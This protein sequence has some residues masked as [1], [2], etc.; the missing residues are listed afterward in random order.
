MGHDRNY[1]IQTGPRSG[2]KP[3]HQTRHEAQ[4]AVAAVQWAERWAR[5]AGWAPCE[6]WVSKEVGSEVLATRNV[7]PF[8][9]TGAEC[10][11]RI[12]RNMDACRESFNDRFTMA[13]LIAIHE[14]FL[15]SGWDI[16]PDQWE[17]RQVQEALQGKPP[18]W[19]EDERPIYD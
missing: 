6:V 11:R 15:S 7:T 1:Y 16:Y 14:A 10:L 18:R 13:E 9:H 17:E 8:E 2:G 3:S 19:N 12:V 4:H 5:Q